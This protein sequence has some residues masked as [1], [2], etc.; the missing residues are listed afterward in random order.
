MRS[1][2]ARAYGVPRVLTG[3]DERPAQCA[4]VTGGPVAKRSELQT[5]NSRRITTIAEMSNATADL[6]ALIH[7][8]L[9]EWNVTGEWFARDHLVAQAAAAGGFGPWLRR[10]AGDEDWPVTVHPPYR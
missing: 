8:K 3:L 1:S 10:L 4:R 7:S 2:V 6:E 9:D 5:G